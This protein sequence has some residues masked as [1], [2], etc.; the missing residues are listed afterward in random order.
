MVRNLKWAECLEGGGLGLE[1][2]CESVGLLN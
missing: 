1:G 2:M